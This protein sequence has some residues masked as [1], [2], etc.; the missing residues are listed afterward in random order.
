MKYL[1]FYAVD[2][3]LWS[4]ALVLVLVLVSRISGHRPS[5]AQAVWK[6]LLALY[7]A[8]VYNVAG[9]PELPYIYPRLNINLVPFWDITN[10]VEAYLINS[11]LNILLF[12][13][14][15]FIL[16]LLWKEFRSRR[17]MCLTGF[18]L[19]LGIELAQLLNYRISD[20]DDLLMNTLGAFLGYELMLLLSR[21]KKSLLIQE[22]ADGRKMFLSI[23]GVVVAVMFALRPY[24]T[25]AVSGILL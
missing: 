8:A 2:M 23:L 25:R 12:V 11:G 19:S 17:T 10:G 20:V 7:L 18:L 16:P 24:I 4:A 3:L 13:P 5:R 9:A 14:L 6:L 21:K 22:Q 15:G 1:I